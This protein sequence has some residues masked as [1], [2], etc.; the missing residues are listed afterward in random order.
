MDRIGRD[1]GSYTRG[2][3]VLYCDVDIYS[4]RFIEEFNDHM[5]FQFISTLLSIHV[6]ITFGVCV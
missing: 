3:D 6:N 2:L 4:N 5:P 1:T